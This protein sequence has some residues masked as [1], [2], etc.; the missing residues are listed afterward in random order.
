MA[1]EQGTQQSTYW[2]N[3]TEKKWIYKWRIYDIHI[4]R[5]I[6]TSKR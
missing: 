4:F 5:I 6:L 1:E 2:L 3:S